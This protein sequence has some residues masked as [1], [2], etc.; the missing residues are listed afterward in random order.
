M[1][2]L[3]FFALIFV[4]L[5]GGVFFYLK[6]STPIVTSSIVRSDDGKTVVVGIGNK[7]FTHLKVTHVKVNNHADPNV[8][9][10]QVKNDQEGFIASTDSKDMKNMEMKDLKEVVISKG[11]TKDKDIKY[12]LTVNHYEPIH[13]LHI[14][15]N[16]LGI[17]YNET[18]TFDE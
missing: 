15:Y 3:L 4:L 17:G 16:Y 11:T 2:K 10:Y 5:I 9:K 18:I 8:T 1:K 14:K 12:G 13:S 7:G 6:V